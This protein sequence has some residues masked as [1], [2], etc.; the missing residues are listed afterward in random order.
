MASQVVVWLGLSSA[1]TKKAFKFINRHSSKYVKTLKGID[2][3]FHWTESARMKLEDVC[4]RDY[5][6]RVWII[7]EIG[8][9]SNIQ[10]VCGNYQFPWDNLHHV[11][12]AMRPSTPELV[13]SLGW[14]HIRRQEHPTRRQEHPI[15]LQSLLIYGFAGLA[16]DWAE[17]S[18]PI[19]YDKS[20]LY[21]HGDVLSFY[22]DR[23]VQSCSFIFMK[24]VYSDL[25]QLS[26]LIWNQLAASKLDLVL[27]KQIFPVANGTA[28]QIDE[29]MFQQVAEAVQRTFIKVG[30]NEILPFWLFLLSKSE[31]QWVSSRLQN[32]ESRKAAST[33]DFCHFCSIKKYEFDLELIIE[34]IDNP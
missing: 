1:G 12:D 22:S 5:W 11:L 34:R 19:D 32:V 25:L 2:A 20:L 7:Q 21:L 9:A 27:A 3:K 17:A 30:V 23:A 4:K 33:A 31:L 24:E 26:W 28:R 14:L 8:L 13:A 16:C 15:T 10:V 18:I 29:A 6:S